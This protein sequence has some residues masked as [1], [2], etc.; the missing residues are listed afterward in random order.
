MKSK[1]A[2][3]LWAANPDAPH[4]CAA[5]FFNA[6][7]AG[8]MDVS[9]EIYFTGKSVLL[10]LPGVAQTLAS[11]PRERRS[12][13]DFMQHAAE[14]GVKFYACSQA[15]DE[16]GLAAEELIE[17]LTGTAGAATYMSRALDEEWSV[18]VF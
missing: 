3:L 12:V 17:Q 18:L 6:A 15:L 14:H 2:I 16:H 1:L 13:H 4:L 9:V 8:A 7:V 11:G 5:P 10:L